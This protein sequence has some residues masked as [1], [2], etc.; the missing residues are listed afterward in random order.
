MTL[1]AA[2]N[3]RDTLEDVLKEN[4]D[5]PSQI[6]SDKT[7]YRK[8]V[9]EYTDY[10]IGRKLPDSTN[11]FSEEDIASHNIKIENPQILR[12]MSKWCE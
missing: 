5:N 6:L 4:R 8:K 3:K 7:K 12:L 10:K 1:R 11:L 9:E 2:V